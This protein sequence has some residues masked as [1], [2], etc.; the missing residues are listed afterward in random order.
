MK[1][2]LPLRT[3][4]IVLFC[5]LITVP[6][7]LIGTITYFKY[8]SDVERNTLELTRQI[9]DQIR[10]NLDRYIKEA[11][12]LTLTPHYDDNVME[13]LRRHDGPHRDRIYLT[14]EETTKMNLFISSLSFDRTE[15]EGMLIF[16][17]DGSVFSNLDVTV[18]RS[19]DR[20]TS[21][22]MEPVKR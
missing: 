5:L 20:H 7:L 4:F 19:W 21:P 8:R 22:W 17:N 12:R 16:A 18:K 15:I 11:E 9:V 13:I 6:L 1:F 14:T 3:K 10:I 2:F